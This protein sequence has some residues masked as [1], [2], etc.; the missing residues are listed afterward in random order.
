MKFIYNPI[1]NGAPIDG[2][3]FEGTVYSHEVGKIY[4]YK[5][6][7]AEELL[8]T[9]GFLQDLSKVEVEE[10]LA[11]KIPKKFGCE[12]CEFSSDVEIALKGHM[13]SHKKEI[14]EKEAAERI[15]ESLVPAAE[16]AP[17][18][19]FA[20]VPMQQPAVRNRVLDETNGEDFY[21]AGFTEKRGE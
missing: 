3:N 2:F 12:Y 21:G 16:G 8:S 6:A 17:A 14:E 20:G 13:K 5:E 19:I 10:I 4:Q 7:V 1:E 18:Q 15:D 11:R 9:Y